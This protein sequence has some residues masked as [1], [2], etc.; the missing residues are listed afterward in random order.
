[1]IICGTAVRYHGSS[2]ISR[3]YLLVRQGARN[4]DLL[5]LPAMPPKTVSG[6]VMAHQ[7]RMITTM[8]PNGRAAVDCEQQREEGRMRGGAGV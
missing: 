4:S 1:M 5:F 3:G 8:V 7:M 2:G 6:I